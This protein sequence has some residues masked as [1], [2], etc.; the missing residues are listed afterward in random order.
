MG[1]IPRPC[2]FMKISNLSNPRMWAAMVRGAPEMSTSCLSLA[3]SAVDRS[4]DWS[5]LLNNLASAPALRP[6]ASSLVA[7][8]AFS[9]FSLSKRG[10]FVEDSPSTLSFLAGAAGLLTNDRIAA[11]L[12]S[13][14]IGDDPWWTLLF[15]HSPNPSWKA[16][17]SKNN[18]SEAVARNQN[19]SRREASL[20]R[21]SDTSDSKLLESWK[22]LWAKSDAELAF[23]ATT[24]AMS[25]RGDASTAWA[26]ASSKTGSERILRVHRLAWAMIITQDKPPW[27]WSIW[28]TIVSKQ[29][30]TCNWKVQSDRIS[31]R[32][33]TSRYGPTEQHALMNDW[34]ALRSHHR[35]LRVPTCSGAW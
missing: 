3:I 6:M 1:Y 26:K 13:L 11:S 27:T 21:T 29:I 15:S 33:R 2:M 10:V 8:R 16:V 19:C 24:N 31:K 28:F 4:S 22:T 18:F 14:D 9:A 17:D 7:Q 12:R 25:P 30:K 23:I 5:S 20:Q 35:T 34:T 32:A